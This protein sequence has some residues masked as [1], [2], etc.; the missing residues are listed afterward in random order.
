MY[1][2]EIFIEI[3]YI[4][5]IL[6]H[7]IITNTHKSQVLFV[8]S[9]MINV[10]RAWARKVE[11]PFIEQG[12][13]SLFISIFKNTPQFC[14]MVEDFL[15]VVCKLSLGVHQKLAIYLLVP[16]WWCSYAGC[17]N[18]NP[19]L[20]PTFPPTSPDK[21]CRGGGATYSSTNICSPPQWRSGMACNRLF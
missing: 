21:I 20:L 12:T 14:W 7:W 13:Y 4:A 10:V 8:W 15:K 11:G 3:I 17:W 1:E 16:W 2:K 5:V 9:C 18:R 19:H 6:Y